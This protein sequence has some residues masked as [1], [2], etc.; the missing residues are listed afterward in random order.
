MEN[1]I[2]QISAKNLGELNRRSYCSRCFWLKTKL[3]NRLPYQIFPGIFS[4]IDSYTKKMVESHIDRFRRAPDWIENLELGEITG[5]IKTTR[6]TFFLEDKE[7][8]IKLT[9]DPDQIFQV[10]DGSSILIDYKTSKITKHQDSM[11][12]IYEFQLNGYRLIAENIGIT[13]I[14]KMALVYTEPQTD[15]FSENSILKKDGFHMNFR[16]VAKNVDINPDIVKSKMTLARKIMNQSQMPNPRSYFA[17]GKQV[18]CG[19]CD[20]FN[21]IL[22]FYK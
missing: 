5:Y 15:Q 6:K 2:I 22:S 4:S 20:R 10:A 21:S 19:D 11:F 9:G 3:K 18:V 14:N 17:N 7:L 8:G 1:E 13:S 16:S 12:P